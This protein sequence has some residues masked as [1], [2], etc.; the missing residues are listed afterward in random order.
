MGTGTALVI[1][2]GGS[3]EISLSS[4]EA[5]LVRA[6]SGL[7]FNGDRAAYDLRT[8]WRRGRTGRRKARRAAGASQLHGALRLQGPIYN[9]FG[10]EPSEG[11]GHMIVPANWAMSGKHFRDGFGRQR[12]R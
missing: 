8:V 4:R 6:L 9:Q 10:I 12:S 5:S 1:D 3:Q 11:F 2:F 7:G